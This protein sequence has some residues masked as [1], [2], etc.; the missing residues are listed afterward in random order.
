MT[1]GVERAMGGSALRVSVFLPLACGRHTHSV[2]V[3]GV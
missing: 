3:L 2:G 1:G